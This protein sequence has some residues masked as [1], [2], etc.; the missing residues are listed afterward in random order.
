MGLDI[1][2]SSIG[3]SKQGMSAVKDAIKL[4]LIEKSIESIKGDVET[5]KTNIDDY[6]HGASATAFSAKV[7]AEKS[8]VCTILG[9]LEEKMELDLGVM[10]TNTAVADAE[11]ATA[12]VGLTK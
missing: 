8:K 1:G 9:V 5:L 3:V 4:D 2:S 10:A 11:V 6:W 7:E 12:I